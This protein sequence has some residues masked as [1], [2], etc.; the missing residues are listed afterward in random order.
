MKHSSSDHLPGKFE[1]WFVLEWL[2]DCIKTR[3]ADFLSVQDS[4]IFLNIYSGGIP[5]TL[6]PYVQRILFTFIGTNWHIFH[7]DLHRLLP[8]E[9]SHHGRDSKQ[10]VLWLLVRQQQQQRKVALQDDVIGSADWSAIVE[11]EPGG[12]TGAETG[13]PLLLFS[14]PW[15]YFAQR[16]RLGCKAIAG[17]VFD[18]FEGK[19][20]ESCVV[21]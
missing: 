5:T 12:G 13:G 1:R 16:H 10:A 3:F 21:L 8:G 11:R 14:H 15:G 20:S 18:S 19:L 6:T 17:N 9:L 2:E 7:V 4:W